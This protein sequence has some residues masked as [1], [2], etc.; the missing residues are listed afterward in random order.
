MF[1]SED[2]KK[3]TSK[4]PMSNREFGAAIIA[5]F[6]GIGA[7]G[8]W[9]NQRAIEAWYVYNFEKVWVSA[10]L[11]VATII[12]AITYFVSRRSKNVVERIRDLEKVS[13]KNDESVY[14]GRTEDGAKVFVPNSTRTGHVQI[15]G[16]T[17]RGK[18]HGVIKPWILRD[19]ASHKDV[20]VIDGKGS[21]EIE[22]ELKSLKKNVNRYVFDM[23]TPDRSI[24]INPLKHGSVAEITDRLFTA[25]EF[26]ESEYY[27]NLQY[28]TTLLLV[29]LIKTNIEAVTFKRLYELLTNDEELIALANAEPN[30]L[31]ERRVQDYLKVPQNKRRETH[32]GLI[33][34]L[35]PFA[36]GELSEILNGDWYEPFRE[37][38]SVSI[39]DLLLGIHESSMFL[40]IYNEKYPTVMIFNLPTM[41]Y[42]MLAAKV[43]K[44][45]FQE[46]AWAISEREKVRRTNF[47]P[48]FMDEFS[49]FVYE[50]FINILNKAR[51]SGVALHLSHQSM[52]DLSQVSDDFAKSLNTNTNVK[53]ILGLNDPDTADFFARHIG[54][55]TQKKMTEKM[56]RKGIFNDFEE[57][58]HAS[59]R[60]AE[61]YKVHPNTLK[62][63]GIGNGVLHL[64]F[65]EGDSF[66]EVVNFD[67]FCSS[68]MR[69]KQEENKSIWEVLIGY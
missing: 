67:A 38:V 8:L 28:D 29:T 31:H 47:T 46:M 25:F 42:P 32:S 51:S 1:L 34:Q 18:T 5:I 58:G 22:S 12:C 14:A 40:P 69:Q 21:S 6:T 65:K 54:T 9:N 56:Q 68:E 11:A 61:S 43:G 55:R 7:L 59:M 39:S 3:Q 26:K 41:K 16:S 50:G 35:T 4:E 23:M 2:S 15:I 30:K 24:Q 37:D 57:M 60:E 20:V 45:I 63:L 48:V 27:R 49:S 53:C 19:L 52:G 44:L 62:G 17:G 33:S 64:P 36:V 13:K 10:F 66:S